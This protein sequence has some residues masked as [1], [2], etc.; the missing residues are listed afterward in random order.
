MRVLSKET[1]TLRD[2]AHW[3][4]TGGCKRQRL[5]LSLASVDLWRPTFELLQCGHCGCVRK[6]NFSFFVF[7]KDLLKGYFFLKKDY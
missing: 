4:S 2:I 6:E 1:R 5:K 7:W 3:L